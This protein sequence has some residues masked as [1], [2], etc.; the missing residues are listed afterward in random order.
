MALTQIEFDHIMS[1]QKQFEDS[2]TPLI[3]GPGPIRWTRILVSTETKE[4]F[5][6]D[7]RK[8]HISISKFT[9]NHRF[10]NSVN[11]LR[12]DH[13]GRHTNPDGVTL[14]GPHIHLYREGFDDKFAVPATE[15]GINIS[16]EI[17]LIFRKVL[18]I[19]NIQNSPAINL[20]LL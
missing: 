17:Q 19:C 6:M 16:D 11:L 1:L 5:I 14:D 4:E 9:I 2:I 18:Q 7:Y 3:L 13:T 12:Y 15:M 20:N 10:R 8:G